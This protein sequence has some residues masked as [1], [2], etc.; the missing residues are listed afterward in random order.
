MW[1]K[2]DFQIN[3]SPSLT[4]WVCCDFSIKFVGVATSSRHRF[5]HSKFI[6]IHVEPGRTTH[7][8][9]VRP[10]ATSM[11]PILDHSQV[12]PPP[13]LHHSLHELS[14][15][16]IPEAEVVPFLI[17]NLQLV[18][19]LYG[20]ERARVMD[21]QTSADNDWN[22]DILLVFNS[23]LAF[24]FSFAIDSAE[25]WKTLSLSNGASS[26]LINSS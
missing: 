11:L 6:P 26:L 10:S 12:T 16:S 7:H 23:E 19:W 8:H 25:K 24:A 9:T 5:S 21:L 14:F 2:A 13:S 4:T 22:E 20:M 3:A 1:R 15:Q 18:F 17:A